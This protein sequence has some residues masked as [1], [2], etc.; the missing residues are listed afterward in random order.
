MLLQDRFYTLTALVRMLRMAEKLS[1][2]ASN[3]TRT[4]VILSILNTIVSMNAEN[5]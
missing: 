5:Y 4:M 2:T 1:T 3:A